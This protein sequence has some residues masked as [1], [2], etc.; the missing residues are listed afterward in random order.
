MRPALAADRESRAIALVD[1]GRELFKAGQFEKAREKFLKARALVPEAMNPYYLLGISAAKLGRC[2]EAVANLD[3]FLRRVPAADE[4]VKD[5][6]AARTR[7]EESLRGRT[8]VVVSS[9]PAGAEVRFDGTPEVVASPLGADELKP[10]RHEL[11]IRLPGY[12]VLSR[13][14]VVREGELTRVDLSL[15]PIA[16]PPPPSRKRSNT[17]WIA[18]GVLGGIAVVGGAVGV[19]FVLTQPQDIPV[20]PAVTG[21][22]P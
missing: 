22:A 8:A 3:W 6:I 20:F 15:E 1:E 10:G 11:S 17:G 21:T 2:V 4:R 13:N 7:C 16:Q 18:G 12:T 14:V 19:T 9:T 5:G